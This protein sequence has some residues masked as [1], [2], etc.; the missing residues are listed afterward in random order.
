MEK[1]LE[2]KNFIDI[3]SPLEDI[4][5]ELRTLKYSVEDK[6]KFCLY[7]NGWNSAIREDGLKAIDDMSIFGH[8]IFPAGE[9]FLKQ[10]GGMSIKGMKF[11]PWF[12]K[13]TTEISSYDYYIDIT[14][15]VDIWEIS[16]LEILQ[17]KKNELLIPIASEERIWTIPNLYLSETGKV[18]S[19][20]EGQ[21]GV[22]AP[23]LLSY[24]AQIFGFVERLSPENRHEKIFSEYDLLD[25]IEKDIDQGVYMLYAQRRF[26]KN[27][28][29]EN[30]KIADDSFTKWLLSISEVNI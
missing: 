3:Q 18:Y 11:P 25:N 8:Y 7:L 10:F 23:N 17:T 4:Y 1:Y 29:V 13:G 14:K 5:E 22:E 30:A 6:V 19:C 24:F 12:P 20:S 9:A 16:F 27:V 21:I 15:E 28:G 26:A 2:I